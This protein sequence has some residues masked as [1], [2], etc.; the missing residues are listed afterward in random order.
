MRPQHPAGSGRCGSFLHCFTAGGSSTLA[1]YWPLVFQAETVGRSTIRIPKR[2]TFYPLFGPM[3]IGEHWHHIH[4]VKLAYP[5]KMGLS[6]RKAVFQPPIFRCY[7]SFM[8]IHFEKSFSIFR[9]WIGCFCSLPSY[10]TQR[11]KGKLCEAYIYIYIL[12]VI[13]GNCEAH[14][15]RKDDELT[16]FFG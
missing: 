10:F 1:R 14:G 4:C 3:G 9:T 2:S 7:L 8:G 12:Q 13:A 5:L 16:F 6:K 15:K 11:V